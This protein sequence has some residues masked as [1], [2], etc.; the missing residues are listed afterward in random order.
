MR[1]KQTPE[2]VRN[3]ERGRCWVRQAQASRNFGSGIRAHTRDVA[4]RE[5]KLTRGL[6]ACQDGDELPLRKE[7]EATMAPTVSRQV[8]R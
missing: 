7:N 8:G 2:E 1:E 4:E 6:T 3:F 5:E